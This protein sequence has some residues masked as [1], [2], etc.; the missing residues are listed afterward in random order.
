MTDI[1]YIYIISL[2]NRRSVSF[3]IHSSWS[4]ATHQ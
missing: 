1:K 3:V 2:I 4:G